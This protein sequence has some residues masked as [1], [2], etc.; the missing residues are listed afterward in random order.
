V[1]KNNTS[2]AAAEP[3]RHLRK[4]A[5]AIHVSG[6]LS[7]LERKLVNVLLLN[8][9]DKLKTQREHTIPTAMLMAMAGWTGSKNL[10][11][12]KG[13]LKKI[14][15][16]QVE[17]DLLE[18]EQ[19]SAEWR[20]SQLVGE[21][22]IKNGICTYEYPTRLAQMLADPDVYAL[23]DVNVQKK[24]K[25]G[26]ALSLYENCLRF[27]GVGRTRFVP[28]QVWRKL[29]GA[30]A[31]TYDEF[32]RFA[33]MVIKPA[34]EE[35]NRVSNILVEPE[36][37]KEG[38]KVVDMRFLIEPNPQGSLYDTVLPDAREEIRRT[39]TYR[40]LTALGIGDALAVTCIQ[41]DPE[42]AAQT[43]AYVEK[44]HKA[45][46]IRS[47]VGGYAMRV[48]ESGSPLD[49]FPDEPAESVPLEAA[50]RAVTGTEAKPTSEAAEKKSRRT[51]AAI[52]GMTPSEMT[53]HVNEYVA[54]GGDAASYDADSGVFK[55]VLQKTGF[56]AWLRARIAVTVEE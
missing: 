44:K 38:R 13:A 25:K 10:D 4:A 11:T 14:A 6:E 45:K 32:K 40:L 22:S 34:V 7:L 49:L 5:A 3:Q 8:A 43:A 21:V 31:S 30:E 16:T 20:A 54:Q 27:K 29:L 53:M 1:T 46:A 28:L 50:P 9:Y 41:S 12:L 33:S 15:I 23:I 52:L 48:F 39:D 17:F 19:R 55:N 24:F 35:V 36:Y 47:S 42:R 26:Y 18:T 37:R 51:T 56:M 2:I